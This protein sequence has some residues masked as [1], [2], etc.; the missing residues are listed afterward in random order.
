[1]RTI[2][3]ILVLLA[4]G[5]VSPAAQQREGI[6]VHGD[7][8]IE[9]LN[10]D[11]T[12]AQRHEFKNALVL[13]H[14]D[15]ALADL[16]SRKVSAGRWEVRLFPEDDQHLTGAV[17]AKGGDPSQCVVTEPYPGS[18]DNLQEF[19]TLQVLNPLGPL[20]KLELV[21]SATA[22]RAGNIK[23]VDTRI[24]RCAPTT[25]PAECLVTPPGPAAAAIVLTRRDLPDPIS[26]TVGQIVQVKV[27]LSFS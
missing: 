4:L 20:G 14:G 7:W 3:A 9:V 5:V 26:I 23:S 25:G 21:G 15:V 27:V 8:V 11:G 24:Y 13:G 12:L 6:R 10:A 18:T 1:M 2:A 19:Y 22:S 17:C 16:L